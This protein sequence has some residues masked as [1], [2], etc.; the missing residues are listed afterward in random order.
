MLGL[1]AKKVGEF[2]TEISFSFPCCFLLGVVTPLDFVELYGTPPS[3]MDILVQ[4]SNQ[5]LSVGQNVVQVYGEVVNVLE[6]FRSLGKFQ[7][8]LKLRYVKH[9]VKL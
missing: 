5:S 8:L 4:Y 1:G 6:N 3:Q 9:I 7:T 2:S